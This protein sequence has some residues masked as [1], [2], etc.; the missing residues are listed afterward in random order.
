MI[1]ELHQ[2]DHDREESEDMKDQNQ[3]F[4]VCQSL[5]ADGVDGDSKGK[6]RPS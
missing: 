2:G 4:E 5:A 6:H 3:A 1:G